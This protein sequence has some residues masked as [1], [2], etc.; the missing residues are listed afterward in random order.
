MKH[1]TARFT[2]F[3][4]ELLIREALRLCLQSTHTRAHTHTRTHV[5][6]HTHI[7]KLIYPS[8]TDLSMTKIVPL[9]LAGSSYGPVAV[10]SIKSI[11]Q[12]NLKLRIHFKNSAL[13]IAHCL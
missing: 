6:T 7:N 13:K 4:E 2:A 10:L 8:S 11:I 3:N 5:L 1:N 9:D 12:P